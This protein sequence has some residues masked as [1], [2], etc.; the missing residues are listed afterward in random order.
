MALSDVVQVT[1]SLTNPGVTQAGF[2]V[3]LIASPNAAW[4]ERTRTYT[5]LDGVASDWGTGTPEYLA[6]Q[7]M[8]SQTTGLAR[9]M[10]GRCALKPTQRFSV[11]AVVA[12]ANAVY[13]LRVGA[14]SSNVFTD[15]EADYT[16][17][18]AAAWVA[19][20]AY[21]AGQ[22]IVNDTGPL[23]Y[24][25]CI[26]PGTS[27]GATG[28]TG[29]NA[30][31]TDGTVHWMYAGAGTLG[32][33]TNDAIVYGLKLLLDGFAAPVLTTANTLTGAVGSKALQILANTAGD[34]FAVEALDLA[35][36]ATKQNH[37][38]PGIATDLVALK[39]A[40]SAWY[41]LVTL[42]N[43][44]ALILAAAAWAEAN[45]KLYIVASL[46]SEISTVA[47]S[48]ATD[49]AQQLSNLA[50]ARTGMIFHPANDEFADAAEI[51]RWFPINPGGDDWRMK[52]LAGVT[53]KEYS[54]TQTTN[55]TDKFVNWYADFG[56]ANVVQGEGKVAAD[57]YIDVIRF[58]DWYKA[59]LQERGA[60]LI[61]QAEKIPFTDA[62]IAIFE[63][64][65]K[66]LNTEGIRVGGIASDPAPVVIV[67]LAADVSTADKAARWLRGV[68]TTWELAGAIHKLSVTVQATP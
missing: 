37:A 51:A 46:D 7:Q 19:L 34:F 22:L 56:G 53:V 57:E 38:D 2:G 24:Y 64:M 8:F 39:K 1:F 21:T 12:T 23:K 48:I 17:T 42:H 43:S 33:T 36:L 18:P 63:T 31:I 67:P 40:S 50:Y 28:P 32:G 29:T 6:A 68:S 11:S 41:G 49:V 47:A 58:R 15:Q 45:E 9:L 66:G 16:A 61:I 4:V 55:M 52:T 35:F 27:A 62:G 59:R 65:I 10:I 14:N 44:E 3:P 13:K 26:T 60:N 25:I 54:D 30:D 20:T 5:S